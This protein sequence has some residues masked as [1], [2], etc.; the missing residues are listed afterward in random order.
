MIEIGVA[1]LLVLLLGS[2]LLWAGGGK[3]LHEAQGS[4]IIESIPDALERQP[5]APQTLGVLS[6]TMVYGLGTRFHGTCSTEVAAIYDRLDQIVET[7]AVSG[8]DVALLQEVDFASRRTHD[9]DQLYYIAAALGWGFAARAITWECRYLPWPPRRPAGR[10]RAGMGVISRYP[11]LQNTRQRL[12]QPRTQPIL[13]ALFAPFHTVQMVDVQCGSQTVRL[14]HVHL[15]A[16]DAAT[17]QQQARELV[18]FVQQVETPT[19]VCMGAFNVAVADPATDAPDQTMAIMTEGLQGRFR[20]VADHAL[21]SPAASPPS[22]QAQVLTG[23][24][25]RALETRI[26]TLDDPV[27]DHLPMVTHLHWGGKIVSPPLTVLPS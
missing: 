23:S 10:L 9:I 5:V 18:T 27:P 22:R 20:M 14:F 6:Y 4:G 7:I 11:L 15:D 1:L 25:V 24:G 13:S 19:S 16:R 21:T 2:A 8:A 26:L 3:I 12:S 17:R